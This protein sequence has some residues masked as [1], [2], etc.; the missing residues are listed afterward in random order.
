M[1]LSQASTHAHLAT[2]CLA[3]PELHALPKI[4]QVE[5]VHSSHT[6]LN[7]ERVIKLMHNLMHES[8]A[9]YVFLRKDTHLCM[10][11]LRSSR[12]GG[13]SIHALMCDDGCTRSPRPQH[14]LLHSQQM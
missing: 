7:I 1:K 11:Q 14:I 3:D 9:V 13:G 4:V 8:K 12:N 2:V 5:R 6:S 10:L